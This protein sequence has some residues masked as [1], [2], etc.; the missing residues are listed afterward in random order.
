M[1]RYCFLFF[2]LFVGFQAAA[3]RKFEIWNKN[4][5]GVPLSDKFLL[6]I[7]EKVHYRPAENS[8]EQY[9]GDLF[10]A[11]SLSDWIKVSAGFRIV[12]A[13]DSVNAWQTESRPM[14]RMDLNKKLGKLAFLSYNRLEYRMYK[15]SDDYCRY[16]QGLKLQL[17]KLTPWHIQFF[18]SEELFVK[19]NGAGTHKARFYGGLDSALGTRTKISAFY[20]L[21][22]TKSSGEWGN[23]DI[24]GVKLYI[25]I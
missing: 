12:E 2:L 15:G 20:V 24:L 18:T 5:I 6:K 23:T 10:V 16:K 22:K 13:K 25:A 14:L 4:Q 21:Q 1:Y 8:V 9:Y 11:R 7:S 17:P 19:L 3:Q